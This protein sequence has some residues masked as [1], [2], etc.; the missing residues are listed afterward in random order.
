MT[1]AVTSAVVYPGIAPSGWAAV[2]PFMEQ[3]PDGR[4]RAAE[5]SAALGWDLPRALR[6]AVGGDV[7]SEPVA[8][9]V[10]TVALADRSRRELG[11]QPD[12]CAGPSFGQFA[13]IA[14]TNVLDFPDAVRLTAAVAGREAS[15][16]AESHPELVSHYFFRVDPEEFAERLSALSATERGVEIVAELQEGFHI[17]TLPRRL[18]PAL[19]EVVRSAGGVPLHTAETPVHSTRFGAL[20][21]EV[22]ALCDRD[23]RLRDPDVPIVSD[24]DG[25]IV[26]T[27][28]GVRDL[29][30]GGF[31]SPVRWRTAL[32]VLAAMGVTDVCVPGPANLF[33]RLCPGMRMLAVGPAGVRASSGSGMAA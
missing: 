31:S 22:V 24:L 6:A 7:V 1:G 11:V 3:D 25:S 27:A 19:R 14:D 23:F 15:Y 18:V 32:E 33:D 2:G 17:V 13:A 4:R 20:R 10:N 28:D 30:A 16:F 8:F 21:D 12:V 29:V 9:M 26:R 5:A